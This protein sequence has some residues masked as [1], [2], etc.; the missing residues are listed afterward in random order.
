MFEMS[1][2]WSLNEGLIYSHT[3]LGKPRWRTLQVW[4]QDAVSGFSF[5]VSQEMQTWYRDS[6]I[7]ILDSWW[8]CEK[9]R[10]EN[11]KNNYLAKIIWKLLI[12]PEPPYVNC[13]TP[14]RQEQ[15]KNYLRISPLQEYFQP[16]K[17]SP[18]LSEITTASLPS[19][20]PWRTILAK[21]DFPQ[22]RDVSSV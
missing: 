19:Q 10:E 8:F 3:C 16:G 7:C 18:Q 9:R 1:Y 4:R 21:Q 22:D 2:L 17:P 15:M 11:L 5:S 12:S 13:L 14:C 6:E 20:I